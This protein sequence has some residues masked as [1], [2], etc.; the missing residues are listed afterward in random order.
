MNVLFANPKVAFTGTSSDAL[1]K[2]YAQEWLSDFREPWLAFNL[3]RRT[4]N[5]P[6][7]PNS[8]PSSGN[9]SF[10]RL[11][12]AQDEAVNNTVNYNAEISKLGGN[13]TNVKV[14]WMK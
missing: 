8:N 3:W 11:P 7:D 9:T 10:Y 14:W 4:G 1:S 2:I 13:N 12:Y 6:V 5:T